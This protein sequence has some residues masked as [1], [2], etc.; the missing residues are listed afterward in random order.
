MPRFFKERFIGDR[1]ESMA[2][3]IVFSPLPVPRTPGVS[4]AIEHAH[5]DEKLAAVYDRMYPDPSETELTVDFVS[6]L[7]PPGG[8]ILELGIGTGRVAVP[9]AERGFRVHGIDGSPAMLDE[10]RKRDPEKRI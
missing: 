3:S 9:L 10:L 2:S 7:T 8:R 6:A 1:S 4:V 5:Y